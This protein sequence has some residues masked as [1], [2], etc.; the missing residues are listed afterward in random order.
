[1]GAAVTAAEPVTDGVAAREGRAIPA[2]ESRIRRRRHLAKEV[3]I[4]RMKVE[5]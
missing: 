4:L 1:M 3:G 2:A 5:G